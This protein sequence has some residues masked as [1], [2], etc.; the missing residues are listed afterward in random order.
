M[1]AVFLSWL[2]RW[3]AENPR[4][5]V[6]NLGSVA[7]MWE[8]LC[9]AVGMGNRNLASEDMHVSFPHFPDGFNHLLGAVEA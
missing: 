5:W 3:A 8:R 9:I 7:G 4:A 1:A 2:W 6:G